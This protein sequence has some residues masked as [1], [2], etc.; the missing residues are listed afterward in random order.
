MIKKAV[1]RVFSA[2]QRNKPEDSD[3]KVKANTVFGNKPF[4]LPLR[5]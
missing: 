2:H 4:N 5:K 1:K 3:T